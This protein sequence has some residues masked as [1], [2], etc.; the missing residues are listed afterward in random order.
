[1]DGAWN[2][3]QP[4]YQQIRD[5]V[6][7]MMLDGV[8]SEGDPIP[9][10]RQTAAECQVNPLTVMKAYQQLSDDGLVEKRRGLGMFVAPGALKRLAGTERQKFLDEQW[11]ETL[12]T[13]RRL[14]LS[15]EELLNQE[16]GQ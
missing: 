11:P 10:V 13:I 15:L 5:R 14:G 2:D 4:I 9:S 6:V 7:G 8:I 3:T 12:R 1:M 16:N